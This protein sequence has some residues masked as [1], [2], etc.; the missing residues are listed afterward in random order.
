MMRNRV[1]IPTANGHATRNGKALNGK[2]HGGPLP[3]V[4][5][6]AVVAKPAPEPAPK[7][8]APDGERTTTGQF[9][10]GNK[11]G[12]GNPFAR[13]LGALRSAFLNAVTDADVAAVAR[14][15]AEL[16]AAGDVQ[17]ATLFLSYAVGRPLA[18]VNP[19]R[20]DLDAFSIIDSAP[21]KAR[22]AAIL[23]DAVDPAAAATT[24]AAV[25]SVAPTAAALAG[26]KPSD[27]M[28]RTVQDELDAR[29]GKPA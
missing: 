9:A 27:Q 22:L 10:K 18:A 8:P 20:L 25:R 29:V 7:P 19:D 12:L 24:A 6:G 16:A 3:P 5:D 23:L 13:R 11:C 15:L 1:P 26:W 17:A 14:K 28:L 4:S 2:A 21:T